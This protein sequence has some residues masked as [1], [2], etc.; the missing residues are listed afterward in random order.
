MGLPVGAL[1]LMSGCILGILKRP[2]RGLAGKTLPDNSQLKLWWQAIKGDGRVYITASVRFD[3]DG[4]QEGNA[5]LYDAEVPDAPLPI[6]EGQSS[7]IVVD[8]TR[9]FGRIKQ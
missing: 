6:I 7:A 5:A 2:K 1:H 4:A 9:L 8:L 3:S